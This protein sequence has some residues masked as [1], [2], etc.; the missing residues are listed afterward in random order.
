M[1]PTLFNNV[2]WSESSVR[3]SIKEHLPV[4]SFLISISVAA[5][6]DFIISLALVAATGEAFNL[7]D[8]FFLA[9]TL[10]SRLLR[11]WAL[12]ASVAKEKNRQKKN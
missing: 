1:V 10:E 4:F 3:A 5:S 6:S 12:V 8:S 7:S 9:E 11:V 2:K